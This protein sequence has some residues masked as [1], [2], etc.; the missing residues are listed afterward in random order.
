MRRI[1]VNLGPRTYSVLVGPGLLGEAG[2]ECARLGL[3]RRVALVTQPTVARY[4]ARVADALREADFAPV[5]VEVPDGEAAKSLDEA[6]RLWDAFLA[7]GLDRGCAVVAV[8]GG[9][10]GDLAG[11]AAAT[12]MRGVPVVQ[13]PTTLLAQVDASV[14]GKVAVNH[15]SAKNLIG[16]FHQPRLVLIGPDTLGT[17]S[18]RQYRSGLA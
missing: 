4:V 5:V 18:E 11:F 3:G 8:G 13:V 2:R 10:V 9:V 12:Y 17:L 1:T 14:G 6:H 15:P 16:V 7:Q